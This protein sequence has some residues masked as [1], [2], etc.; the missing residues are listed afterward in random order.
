MGY[1]IRQHRVYIHIECPVFGQLTTNTYVQLT[2]SSL[3]M[4]VSPENQ[5]AG[6]AAT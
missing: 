2:N 5:D 3:D 4:V 6:N 1:D